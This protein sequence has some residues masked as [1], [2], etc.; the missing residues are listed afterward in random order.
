[1]STPAEGTP[2]ERSDASRER[3]LVAAGECFAKYGFSRTR[4]DDIAE[5]AGVSRALVH[6]YFGT[7]PKLL[8]AVQEFVVEEWSDAVAR[9]FDEAE[10][11]S[12]ALEAWVRTVLGD[13]DRQPL[14]RALF[15]QDALAASPGWDDVSARVRQEW[16]VRLA[17]LVK[18]GIRSGE[19]RADL[20]VE[21]TAFVM[22]T[23]LS[24]LTAEFFLDSKLP[25]ERRIRGTLDLLLAGLRD[26]AP[27][28]NH[29]PA[30]GRKA[31]PKS[32][33]KKK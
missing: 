20:D 21:A 6:S 3:I 8:R 13:T 5:S 30:K 15:D 2:S 18:R 32:K 28:S 1:M 25:P 16:L 12:E 27:R 14:L 33:G 29:S 24:G 9:L 19:Y 11:P 4:V 17:D 7:K 10:G 23:L 31:K 26:H 22:R